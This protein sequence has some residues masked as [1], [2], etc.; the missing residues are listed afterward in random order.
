MKHYHKYVIRN[1]RINYPWTLHSKAWEMQAFDKM[2][3]MKDCAWL[4]DFNLR[5]SGYSSLENFG[6][7][8][9]NLEMLAALLGKTCK[10]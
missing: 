7:K 9:S 5:Y 10:E 8:T 2:D 1:N 4:S 6:S 3:R